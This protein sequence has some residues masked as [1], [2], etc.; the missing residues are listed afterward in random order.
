M[1]YIEIK[2]QGMNCVGFLLS[3]QPQAQSCKSKNIQPVFPFRKKEIS[4][5]MHD[6]VRGK[7]GWFILHSIVIH[8][9]NIKA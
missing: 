8:L 5:D 9:Y 6:R 7:Y 3:Y 4:T 2:S 1:R